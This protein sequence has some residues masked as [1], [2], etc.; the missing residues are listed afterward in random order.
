[1]TNLTRG[2]NMAKD[3]RRLRV[4]PL[5]HSA[6]S[7][8]LAK[9]ARVGKILG[10]GMIALDAGFRVNSIRN[11]YLDGG[12]WEREAFRQSMG[13]GTSLVFGAVALSL[14]FGPFGLIVSVILAGAAALIVDKFATHYSGRLYDRVF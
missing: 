3:S 4:I 5:S 14:F 10:P 2:L 13:F 8:S 11:I 12:N 7:V 9:F 1:M 6:Q